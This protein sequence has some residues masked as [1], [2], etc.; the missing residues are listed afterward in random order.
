[1]QHEYWIVSLLFETFFKWIM[2]HLFVT[3]QF[4]KAG[5]M[6]LLHLTIFEDHRNSWRFW[7]R[8]YELGALKLVEE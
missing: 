3:E 2:L 8:T 1:M 6:E 5:N 4:R 7:I